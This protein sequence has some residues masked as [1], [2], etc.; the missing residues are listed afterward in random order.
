[1]RNL[2]LLIIA[3][4]VTFSSSFGQEISK[5]Q[6]KHIAKFI[7]AVQNHSEKKVF[8][9]LD[10][11]YR[12]AQ[13]TF[14]EGRK[15]QLIDDL[16]SGSEIDSE[17]FVNGELKNI[18]KIETAEVIANKD[19]SYKY[20]FRIRDGSSDFLIVLSLTKNKKKYGFVGAMG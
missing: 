1:M 9:L 6:H 15:T 4:F 19:G 13:L 5:K 16:F 17:K 11:E 3:L 7:S 20:I 12:K 10:K 18:L 2:Q 8:K 14:L